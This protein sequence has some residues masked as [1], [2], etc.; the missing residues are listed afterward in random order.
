MMTRIACWF[1]LLAITSCSEVRRDS[2]QKQS[3]FDSVS[4]ETI[5]PTNTSASDST[6]LDSPTF[7]EIAF[8]QGV[9][10]LAK[11]ILGPSAHA[12]HSSSVLSPDKDSFY[13]QVPLEELTTFLNRTNKTIKYIYRLK[14][15]KRQY[16]VILHVMECSSIAIANALFNSMHEYSKQDIGVPGLTYTNDYLIMHKHRIYWLNSGCDM[17]YPNHQRFVQL[18]NTTLQVAPNHFIECQCGDLVC[19]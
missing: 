2:S 8:E 6:M 19:R 10:S 15:D 7:G 14:V 4:V 16:S 17:S 11:V 1:G 5:Q 12:I 3:Q 18:L 9:D 13:I